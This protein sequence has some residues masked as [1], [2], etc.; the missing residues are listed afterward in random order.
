MGSQLGA[1]IFSNRMSANPAG[2]T[3][4]RGHA[5]SLS[6]CHHS[7]ASQGEVWRMPH[8]QSCWEGQKR[9]P[10]SKYIAYLHTSQIFMGFDW[11][12][13]RDKPG[14]FHLASRDTREINGL[15]LST[16]ETLPQILMFS[17]SFKGSSITVHLHTTDQR[18]Q[19]LQGNTQSEGSSHWNWQAGLTSLKHSSTFSNS[20]T[21]SSSWMRLFDSITSRWTPSSTWL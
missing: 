8:Q 15:I 4:Q 16:S 7:A 6:A 10:T 3:A 11:S 1:G 20:I 21:S 13:P 17:C 2:A 19:Y 12:T 18:G 9:H 14:D 5:D